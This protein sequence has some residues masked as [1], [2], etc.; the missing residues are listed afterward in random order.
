MGVFRFYRLNLW[1]DSLQISI[2]WRRL[3]GHLSPENERCTAWRRIWSRSRPRGGLAPY[4]RSVASLLVSR[5]DLAVAD[6]VRE[7]LRNTLGTALGRR[8]TMPIAICSKATGFNACRI[9]V[10][11]RLGC[12][13]PQRA[14]RTDQRRI[15]STLPPWRCRIPSSA[16]AAPIS[17]PSWPTAPCGR[18]AR[19][20]DIPLR[21]QCGRCGLQRGN[22]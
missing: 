3:C 7:A 13:S 16:S 19:G 4:V 1:V 18:S 9:S 15:L 8:P 12:C 2:R 21:C 22:A 5:W 14:P 17:V 11:A 20:L 10:R 6:E